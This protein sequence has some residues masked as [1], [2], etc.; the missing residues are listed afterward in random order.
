MYYRYSSL[1]SRA[2]PSGCRGAVAGRGTELQNPA[3]PRR[4]SQSIK[5]WA[6]A[7][8]ITTTAS[9]PGT[10]S[11]V[12]LTSEDRPNAQPSAYFA[13]PLADAKATPTFTPV[14]K[15]QNGPHFHFTTVKAGPVILTRLPHP[16]RSKIR[17]LGRC[18]CSRSQVSSPSRRTGRPEQCRRWK[19]SCLGWRGP[20]CCLR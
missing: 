3:I 1:G 18:R 8:C 7:H 6:W 10:S 2:Q 9:S 13:S 15:C 5:S 20:R 17:R 14:P 11:D 16:V 4:Y 19:Q 12:A